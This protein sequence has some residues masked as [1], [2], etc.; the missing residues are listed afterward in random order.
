MI[1]KVEICGVNTSK[2]PVLKNEE[3]RTLFQAMQSGDSTAREQLIQG[4]LRLVLSVIQ[5]FS[6]RGEYVDDLFQVGCIGLIK[7]IDNFDLSQNVRFSTYAVPMIIGEI[8]RYLR[9][10]N[11]VRVSRSLRDIAYKALQIREKLVSAQ[12]SEPTIAQIAEELQVP[13]EEVVFAL[14]A[15]Q[16][17][18][19]LFEPIY[20]DGGDP[21]L[22][23]DQISDERN[24]DELWLEEIAIKEAMKKLN[25][26]E[27]HIVSLRFFQGKTQ[28]EVAEE[29][30]ISQAQVSRLE[31]AALKQ[32]RKFI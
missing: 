23:M 10:N 14:D 17:P 3:M 24:T 8:R 18:V 27:K 21:I 4:N 28:M 20:N 29:I 25:N 5:R 26:R 31:K 1:N 30:G 12:A 13:R 6:N 7:A 11:A 22:V 16:E 19:S 32:L 15:I 9:D 2:L